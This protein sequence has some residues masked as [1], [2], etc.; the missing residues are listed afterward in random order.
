MAVIIIADGID[1]IHESIADWN[2][3]LLKESGMF[4]SDDIPEQTIK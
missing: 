2:E 4:L 1:K 3:M